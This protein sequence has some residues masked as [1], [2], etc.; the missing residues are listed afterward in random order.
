MTTLEVALNYHAAGLSVIPVS[1]STKKPAIDRW[2]DFAERQPTEYELKRMFVGRDVNIGIITGGVS[3]LV[4]VDIDEPSQ[5]ATFVAQYPTD[6][7]A[8]TPNGYHLYYSYA[9]TDLKNSVRKLADGVDIRGQH[10]YV[11]APPSVMDNGDKYT[12]VE[13]GTPAKLP[14]NL[15]DRI[16]ATN[17]LNVINLNQ[18]T[19]QPDSSDLYQRILKSGFTPGAHNAELKDAARYL[20]RMGWDERT[21]RGEMWRLNQIDPTPLPENEFMATITSGLNYER[22][23]LAAKG[24]PAQAPQQVL[25]PAQPKLEQPPVDFDI[26]EFGD[27][28]RD[29]AGRIENWLIKEWLPES[30]V[31]VTTAPP[32]SFKTWLGLEAGIQIAL[33]DKATPFLGGFEGPKAP[34]PVLFV[35]QEDY[36]GLL[37]QRIATIR[38]AKS[39]EASYPLMDIK[40][41]NDNERFISFGSATQAP[42]MLHTNAQLNFENDESLEKL[43]ASIKKYGFKYV[44]IDP[45]YSLARADDFFASL[46]RKMGIIKKM[47][48]NYGTSFMFVHHNKKGTKNGK[49]SDAG[50]RE[51]MFGSQLL[52][53]AFEGFWLI[54]TVT[55]KQKIIVR[56][57]KVF[58][59]Q[60]R[61]YAVTFDIYTGE[62]LERAHYLPNHAGVDEIEYDDHRRYNVKLSDVEDTDYS[63]EETTV[64]ELI[65][66]F[67]PITQAQIIA[68][69]KLSRQQVSKII[70]NFLAVGRIEVTP[71]TKS[72]KQGMEYRLV[73]QF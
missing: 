23:R 45:V 58:P 15:A 39:R 54:N 19:E 61:K 66:G 31:M 73:D 32:E 67:A 37:A 56:R 20:F 42:I 49:A 21:V 44:M 17:P 29:Y 22:Q 5:Y 41:G 2:L 50:E 25:L 12:W 11:V 30:A 46:A 51:G 35:Q 6:R 26:T 33:G 43:E 27:I 64:L 24:T 13:R 28:E 65:E 71:E 70:Q 48:D 34:A 47:R 3:K 68:E 8:K 59:G 72:K 7:I 9:G 62:P 18:V 57:G 16:R 69:S 4:V 52:N 53:G 1:P 14:R 55:N 36:M 38:S 10:G 40:T 63:A 60:M